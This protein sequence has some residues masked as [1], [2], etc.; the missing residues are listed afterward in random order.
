MTP[1]E[2]GSIF[3][4]KAMHHKDCNLMKIDAINY[5]VGIHGKIINIHYDVSWMNG[6]HGNGRWGD[7]FPAYEDGKIMRH[8]S[9]MTRLDGDGDRHIYRHKVSLATK[10][11]EGLFLL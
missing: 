9:L 3:K 10:L 6:E 1:F 11:P 8:D 5:K 7:V 2:V 4:V